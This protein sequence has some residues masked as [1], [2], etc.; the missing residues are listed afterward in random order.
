MAAPHVLGLLR[1][2]FGAKVRMWACQHALL[3]M[4]N[5][6]RAEASSTVARAE[7]ATMNWTRVHGCRLRG[8]NRQHCQT[9]LAF[10]TAS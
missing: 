2:M 1:E 8:R 3:I 4:Q 6:P 10:G 9:R 7:M 5:T